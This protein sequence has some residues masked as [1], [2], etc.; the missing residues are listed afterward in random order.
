MTN[1]ISRDSELTTY[2]QGT[3]PGFCEA[4]AGAGCHARPIFANPID[5]GASS[6]LNGVVE[7]GHAPALQGA[8]AARAERGAGACA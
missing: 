4:T 7:H 5:L 6:A 3:V 2:L 8:G 1:E